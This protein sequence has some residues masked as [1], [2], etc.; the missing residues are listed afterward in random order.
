MS[1]VQLKMVS[2]SIMKE[3]M[4]SEEFDYEKVLQRMEGVESTE[5]IKSAIAS[6]LFIISNSARFNVN[7]QQLSL[8]LQQIGLPKESSESFCRSYKG[9]RD[10][11]VQHFKTRT[12]RLP[13]IEDLKWRVDFVLS[14][15]AL[16]EVN[17]PSV[18]LCL[19]VAQHNHAFDVSLDQF[20]VL[21]H[22]LKIA[23]KLMD[24]LE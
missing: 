21:H 1:S 19:Q 2:V 16:K 17:E 20:R 15:S 3:L 5:E 7:E 9:A 8:E 23:R 12:M 13:Q 24:Q 18:Q 4:E 14:S 22:E 6:L 10:A 11:L